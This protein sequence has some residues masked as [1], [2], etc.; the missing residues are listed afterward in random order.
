MT[1]ERTEW[2][3][4]NCGGGAKVVRGTYRFT[5][6]GLKEVI[7]V[8]VELVRCGECGNEDPILPHLDGLMQ[9]LAQA[10]I[11]KPWRLAGSEIRFLRK[12]LRMTG[13]EFGRYISVDKF[14][15]SKWENGHDQIGE[16]SDRFVRALALMLGDG[17]RESMERTARMFP[18]I[19]EAMREVEYRYNAETSEVEYA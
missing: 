13:E 9:R 10:V 4:S 7:L 11:E 1:D 17:L 2:V 16:P 19:Q 5:E 15:V 14:C 18:D 3:C 8:G 12:Y 6:S